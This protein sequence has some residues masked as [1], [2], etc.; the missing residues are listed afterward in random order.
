MAEGIDVITGG[1]G[2]S[3]LFFKITLFALPIALTGILQMLYTMAD[4]IV[5]G[6]FSARR[7]GF[8]GSW[9]HERIDGALY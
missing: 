2:N 6:K 7:L 9:L 3:K 4:N 1:S 5:V 8:S